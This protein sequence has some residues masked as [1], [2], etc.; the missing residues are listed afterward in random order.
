LAFLIS[1]SAFV[2]NFG[3]GF[4][5]GFQPS[6]N[7]SNRSS[8]FLDK[9]IILGFCFVIRFSLLAFAPPNEPL[10]TNN[11]YRRGPAD[12]PGIGVH[13]DGIGKNE[14]LEQPSRLRVTHGAVAGIPGLRLQQQLSESVRRGLDHA[15]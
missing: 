2:N 11:G 13:T 5:M 9:T 1:L 3:F 6:D 15:H 12:T 10:P 7:Q 4:S 8:V 14:A